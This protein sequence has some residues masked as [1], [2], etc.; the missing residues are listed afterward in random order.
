M[1]VWQTLVGIALA[2]AG[3]GAT[4]FVA[5]ATLRSSRALALDLAPPVVLFVALAAMTARPVFAGAVLLALLGGLAFTDWVKRAILREPA[6]FSDIG[7]LVELF[8]HPRLYLPFAGPG[9]VILGAVAALG[10]F[11]A[12]LA[13]EPPAWGWW[14]WTA[15]PIPAA[16]IL[17]GWALHGPW[18]R[19]SADRLRGLKPSGEPF[20]DAAALGPLAM[21]ATYS[22]IARDERQARRS[23]ANRQAPA[24][25]GRAA[26][27]QPV[28]VVQCESF[29]DARRLH[30]AIT[31]SLT[32]SFAQA[33]RTG[34][35]Y[36]RLTAPA[37]GA[38]TMRPEFAV[39][40][41]IDEPTLGFDRFNPYFAFAPSA[42]IRSTAPS[43]GAIRSC[44]ISAS[45]SSWARRRL[46]GRGGS[47]AISRI[48]KS[49]A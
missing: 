41:G 47:A 22:L 43:T 46:P 28:F 40:T 48:R 6:V 39:L 15:I 35:Q 16:A 1:A 8:R 38:N 9:R 24:L 42:C 7:E 49:P 44:S 10:A 5:Q 18:L 29:F 12:L 20:R 36:G 30:P 32:P 37:W 27:E 2:A 33:C 45:T 34:A 21:H 26:C 23:L 4:R 25:I 11:I 3:W 17:L 13:L 19:Q 14:P 31:D